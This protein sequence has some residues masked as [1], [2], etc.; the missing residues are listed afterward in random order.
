M[1]D[2]QQQ[3]CYPSQA[4]MKDEVPGKAPLCRLLALYV[5][6]VFLDRMVMP[7]S[8]SM[9]LESMTRSS[10]F[11]LSRKT[12]DCLSMASTSVVLP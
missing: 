10:V 9:L 6:A 5:T 1:Q 8:R 7:R 3:Q 11:W 2:I 4:Y 12:F